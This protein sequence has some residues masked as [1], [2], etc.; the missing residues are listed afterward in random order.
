[1]VEQGIINAFLSRLYK[2][3]IKGVHKKRNRGITLT[4]VTIATDEF[5][6][7][8]KVKEWYD[9]S[10]IQVDSLNAWPSDEQAFRVN[11]EWEPKGKITLVCKE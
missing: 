3:E 8:E 10:G 4:F 6:A 7:T 5:D 1:M 9:L 11:T 2:V